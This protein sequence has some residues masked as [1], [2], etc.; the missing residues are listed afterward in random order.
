MK[1]EIENL[2]NEDRIGNEEFYI[3]I[4]ETD[5]KKYI[6]MDTKTLFE[7]IG[8]QS[9]SLLL[10]YGNWYEGTPEQYQVINEIVGAHMTII[11]DYKRSLDLDMEL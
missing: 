4:P 2:Y 10:K 9:H 8:N 7:K 6:L 1:I 3:F 5:L 11:E